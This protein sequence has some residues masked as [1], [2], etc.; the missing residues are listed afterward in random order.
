MFYEFIFK[1][2]SLNNCFD[3]CV[4]HCHDDD[5][6]ELLCSWDDE[7]FDFLKYDVY[8]YSF[9]YIIDENCFWLCKVFRL[10][11]YDDNLFYDT[12]LSVFISFGTL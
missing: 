5:D 9:C 10:I 2:I 6:N 7:L 4:L 11:T 3:N 1:N 12:K 8:N